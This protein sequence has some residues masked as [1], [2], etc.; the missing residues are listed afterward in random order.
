MVL[1]SKNI[2]HEP[3]KIK[4]MPSVSPICL[5]KISG[6]IYLSFPTL[7]SENFFFIPLFHRVDGWGQGVGRGGV[8]ILNV[9]S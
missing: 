8:V 3:E 1:S 2:P 6:M 9:S 4:V 5:H 7:L